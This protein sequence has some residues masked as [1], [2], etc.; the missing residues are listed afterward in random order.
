MRAFHQMMT[1]L[2]INLSSM[3]E[4]QWENENT[5]SVGPG[6]RLSQLYDVILPKNKLLAA[7]SCGGVGIGGLTLG[8]GYGLFRRKYGLTCDSLSGNYHG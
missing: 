6:C 2:V 1:A 4:I 5:I 7:G 3:K 8:G